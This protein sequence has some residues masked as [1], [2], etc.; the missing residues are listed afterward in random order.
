VRA[1]RYLHLH[2]TCSVTQ[3]FSRKRRSGADSFLTPEWASPTAAT[4]GIQH[5]AADGNEPGVMEPVW[6]AQDLIVPSVA[7]QASVGPSEIHSFV[8]FVLY[9]SEEGVRSLR[10]IYTPLLRFE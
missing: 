5:T 4:V 9:Q 1:Q 2:D 7:A 3:N 8:L 6:P 10:I